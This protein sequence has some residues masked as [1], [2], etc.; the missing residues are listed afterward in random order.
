MR[1]SDWIE[2]FDVKN[3]V[4]NRPVPGPYTSG[5]CRGEF[6]TYVVMKEKIYVLDLHCCFSYEPKNRKWKSWLGETELRSL[7]QESCCV[8]DDMLYTID[9]RCTLG[10]QVVVYDL[11]EEDWKGVDLGKTGISL[12]N[13]F[14]YKSKMAN[15]GGKLVILGCN[16]SRCT[17]GQKD[18]WCVEIALE[19]RQGGETWGKVESVECVLTSPNSP[20]IELCRT[21]TV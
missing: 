5:S 11:K 15:L 21:V 20:T 10:H 3:Q 1:S 12:P 18:I 4:W 16:Q 13:L 19:R 8:V 7:W 14:Y 17:E 9:L 2:V 6:V